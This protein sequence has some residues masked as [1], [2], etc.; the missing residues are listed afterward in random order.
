MTTLRE[1]YCRQRNRTG[2]GLNWERL[3]WERAQA[4]LN[5]LQQGDKTCDEYL[6]MADDINNLM[7]KGNRYNALLTARFMQGISDVVIRRMVHS[8]VD[9]PYTYENAREAYLKATKKK[10][11]RKPERNS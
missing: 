7:G 10:E 3:E 1:K 9:E 2:G 6:E 4:G 11:K 5:V 8:M